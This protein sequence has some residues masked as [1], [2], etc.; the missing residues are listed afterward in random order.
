MKLIKLNS[1]PHVETTEESASCVMPW[2]VVGSKFVTFG[3]NNVEKPM[4]VHN[5]L[6]LLCWYIFHF[7][8]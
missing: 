6:A 5:V 8:N 1:F 2:F 3:V 7:K 4:A